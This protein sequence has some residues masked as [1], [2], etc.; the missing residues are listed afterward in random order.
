[1]SEVLRRYEEAFRLYG[2]TPEGV[3]WPDQAGVDL[4]FQKLIEILDGNPF[5]AMDFG[6]G[7]GAMIPT[8]VE[9]GLTHYCGVEAVDV[10]RKE[11]E[12]RYPEYEFIEVMK[13][14]VDYCFVSGTFNLK[15]GVP[16]WQWTRWVLGTMRDLCRRA[17]KGVAANFMT[18]KPDWKDKTLWYPASIAQITCSLPGKVEVLED[19]GLHEWTLLI[20]K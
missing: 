6:C 13:G 11:A 7:Y 8:L 9:R 18:Y 2:C 10:I 17:R 16:D 4:R 20:R 1:M 15:M 3:V 19:Y 12:L 5:T 14:E